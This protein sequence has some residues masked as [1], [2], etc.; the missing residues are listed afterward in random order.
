MLQ[1]NSLDT[2]FII[3]DGLVFS[4]TFHFSQAWWYR[5]VI[6]ALRR[7]RQKD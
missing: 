2:Q 5:T 1:H 7:L 4:K 6:P 3:E